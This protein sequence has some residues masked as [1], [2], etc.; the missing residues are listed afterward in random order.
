VKL[1]ARYSLPTTYERSVAVEM[2]GL[3]S[4]GPNL[5][6]IYHQLGDYAAQV[7]K[8]TSPADLPVVQPTRFELV[9]NMATAKALGLA[10]PQSVQLRVDTLIE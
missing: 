10:I 2:G 9:L 4:Y 1:A 3:F 7:L 5:L 8:G 6:G